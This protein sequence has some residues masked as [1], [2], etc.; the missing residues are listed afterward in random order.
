MQFSRNNAGTRRG[1]PL[2]FWT[3]GVLAMGVAGLVDAF[4]HDGKSFAI[5]AALPQIELKEDPFVLREA[6][7]N[8]E[9][10][11]GETKI[12]QHQLFKRNEYWFW[13]AG[14]DRSSVVNIHIYDSQ[15]NL[16]EAESWQKENVAG[17]RVKPEMTGTYYIR[18]AI[19]KA[20]EQPAEW[21]V[22]YAYR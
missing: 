16:T 19:E 11:A 17:V 2:G 4:V 21:A 5:E 14:S 3:A 9:L 15:G 1:S 20:G 7:W 22:I 13:L 18:V 10:N 8:G 12:L 6:W